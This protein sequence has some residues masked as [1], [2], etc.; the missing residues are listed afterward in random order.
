MYSIICPQLTP[1]YFSPQVKNKPY[2]P[3]G[4]NAIILDNGA[5]ANKYSISPH[6]HGNIGDYCKTKNGDWTSNGFRTIF[7]HLECGVDFIT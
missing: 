2:E 7:D 4:E 5:V 1:F 3:T 6:I